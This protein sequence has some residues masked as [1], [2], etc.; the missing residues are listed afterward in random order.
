MST[1]DKLLDWA[2]ELQALAQTGLFYG[3]DFF[4]HERCER[5]REIAAEMISQKT[6]LSLELV[7]ELYCSD[8]GYQTPKIDTRSAI[9]Q[10]GKILLVK[11]TSGLWALPGGWCDIGLTPSENAV[12][13]VKEETG[14]DVVVERL[15]ALQDRSKHNAKNSLLSVYKTFFL[16]RSLGGKFQKNNETLATAFFGL[17]EL[18]ELIETK[19][20]AAQI[21]MCFAAAEQPDWQAQFD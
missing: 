11:E 12:K 13:E 1:G 7:T 8:S 9:F 10:D 16:C 18:P 17:D 4:D 19:T 3:K 14:L 15:I 21:T 5:M 2:V 20:T 6:S